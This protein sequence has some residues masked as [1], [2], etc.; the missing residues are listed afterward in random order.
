MTELIELILPN[1]TDDVEA[2][3]ASDVQRREVPGQLARKAGH[4]F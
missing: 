1:P 4:P 2:L 3:K